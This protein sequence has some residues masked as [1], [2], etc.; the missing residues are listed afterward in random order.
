ML[1]IHVSYSLF[2]YFVYNFCISL[3]RILSKLL[4]KCSSYLY[5]KRNWGIPCQFIQPR[6]LSR[7][8]V[9]NL[10]PAGYMRPTGLCAAAREAILNNALMQ[11]ES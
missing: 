6:E 4:F 9:C 11:P 7:T 1:V 2:V 10:R 5:Y 8:G 3:R